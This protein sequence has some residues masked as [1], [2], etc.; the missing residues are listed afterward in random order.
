M[1]IS[2]YC[3]YA[4][5]LISVLIFLFSLSNVFSQDAYRH[6][7]DYINDY[8][9]SERPVPEMPS[10]EK[11]IRIIIDSDAK[12]EVDD[13][14]AIALALL[15]SHRFVIEGFV[16]A[17]Y[18]NPHGGPQS[19]DKSYEEILRLLDKAGMK[20][21]FPVYRGSPPMQYRYAPS[22]SE[23]VDFI[24]RTA[25]NSTPEDPVWI[26]ALGSAT[27]LA[28]AYLQ[29]PEIAKTAVFFWHGRTRWPDKCWNFNVFG[30]R[31]AAMTLFH[32]P[33]P[34]ILFDT[35]THLYCPMEESE[36]MV[37]PHGELGKYLHDIRKTGEWY[38]LSDKGFFDLGD[39]AALVE[40]GLATW[41]VVDCP[42]VDPDLTYKFS[43]KKGKILRCYDI[44]RDGTFELLYERLKSLK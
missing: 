39:I 33:V 30:D 16:A 21:A 2:S 1:K 4:K 28:S 7:L 41:E 12:N 36:T 27:N 37:R 35:G 10:S 3:R 20:G 32:S 14:W 8:D 40:P 9:F 18:D 31:K 43:G 22:G 23:G 13:Q 44:D 38:Q 26:V 42:E 5:G 11:K 19:I 29:D 25:L 24:V 34:L 6:H 17:N 15:S